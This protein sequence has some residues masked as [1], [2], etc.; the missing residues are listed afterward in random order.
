MNIEKIKQAIALLEKIPTV[1]NFWPNRDGATILLKAAIV[2]AEPPEELLPFDLETA[3]A[4]PDRVVL[5]DDDFKLIRF[6]INKE[7]AD[8]PVLAVVFDVGKNRYFND[9]YTKSGQSAIVDAELKLKQK[10]KVLT[11]VWVNRYEMKAQGGFCDRVF[12]NKA[13]AETHYKSWN[14]GSELTFLS[15]AQEREIEL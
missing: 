5:D 11:K 13:D 3:I 9:M 15:V 8:F 10:P 1:E 2:E 12:F 6:T 7:V 14:D 4:E